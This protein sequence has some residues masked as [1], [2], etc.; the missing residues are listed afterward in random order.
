MIKKFTLLGL[1][2]LAP[3]S[4]TF[5]SEWLCSGFFINSDGYIGTAAH[6]TKPNT[7]YTVIYKHTK[8][9]AEAVAIDKK[10]DVAILKINAKTPYYIL[11]PYVNDDKQVY[12]LGYPIPEQRGFDLKI[13][14]GHY[15]YEMDGSFLITNASTCEGNSGGP[16][17]NS[18]NEVVGVLTIGLDSA[19]C[20]Y[21]AGSVKI[22]YLINL[23]FSHGVPLEISYIQ[24][25]IYDKDTIYT[26]DLDKTPI[27]FG[28]NLHE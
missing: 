2:L 13:S 12:T 18:S 27:I 14:S 24:G 28:E 4:S 1:L 17:V 5:A 10:D 21:Y 6:C 22:Q 26:N 20:S 3:I 9:V 15:L 16:T 8:Y 7:K 23:A 25:P 11:N 19:P